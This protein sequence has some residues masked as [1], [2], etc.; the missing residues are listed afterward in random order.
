ME[1]FLK[2]II[3]GFIIAQPLGPVSILCFRRVLTESRLT[4]LVTVFGAALADMIYGLVA[5]LGLHA[6][7]RTLLTHQAPLRIVGGGFLLYL[8]ISMARS[9][10]RDPVRDPT[11]P[12][13]LA[14]AFFS[15]FLLMLAN[16]TVMIS[17]LAVFA[18]IGLSADP[19]LYR[20]GVRLGAGIFLGSSAWWLVYKLAALRFHGRLGSKELKRI[21]LFAGSLI[22]AFGLWQLLDLVRGK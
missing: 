21:N 4:G 15:T 16:P 3:A 2:G 6:V 5:A 17:F 10:P 20:Q 22:C 11:A 13:N 8:G 14:G 9:T 7:T 18:A 12:R 19:E 1:L